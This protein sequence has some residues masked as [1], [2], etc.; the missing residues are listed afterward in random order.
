M[1]SEDGWGTWEET[2]TGSHLDHGE[3]TVTAVIFLS[4]SRSQASCASAQQVNMPTCPGDQAP[5]LWRQIKRKVMKEASG[6]VVITPPSAL[7]VGVLP[8]CQ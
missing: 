4:G 2:S 8:G 6:S 7:P 3:S 5:V 1:R